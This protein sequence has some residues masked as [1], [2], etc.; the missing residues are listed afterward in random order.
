MTKVKGVH[1]GH[2]TKKQ[3]K[4]FCLE[5]SPPENV[6]AVGVPDDLAGPVWASD[7]RYVFAGFPLLC[8]SAGFLRMSDRGYCPIRYY[9]YF[10]FHSNWPAGYN[11]RV[12]W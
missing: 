6:G 10:S 3:I 7:A 9:S 12:F 1:G 8:L 4:A 5:D 11:W 2:G